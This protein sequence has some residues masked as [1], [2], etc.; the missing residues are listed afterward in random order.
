[1]NCD[2]RDIPKA[3]SHSSGLFFVETVQQFCFL[4]FE[5]RINRPLI[6]VFCFYFTMDVDID[7][8]LCL[9]FFTGELFH[10]SLL[11]SLHPVGIVG[12]SQRTS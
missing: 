8:V 11:T 2:L 3:T 5:S 12:S 7:Y 1:M 9:C 10:C 6:T 4:S